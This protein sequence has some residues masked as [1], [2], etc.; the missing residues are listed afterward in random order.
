MTSS[1]RLDPATC[2]LTLLEKSGI[3][4]SRKLLDCDEQRLPLFA[5]GLKL[6]PSDR[7]QAV[8]SASPLIGSMLPKTF[9]PFIPLHAVQEWIQRRQVERQGTF[10]LLLDTSRDL[11]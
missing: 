1:E 6:A 2:V 10:C 11:V 4:F 3:L 8:T 9:D 5:Q 7:R